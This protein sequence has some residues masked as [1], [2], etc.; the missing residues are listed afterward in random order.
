MDL[1]QLRVLREES[2]KQRRIR[3]QYGP[4]QDLIEKQRDIDNAISPLVKAT[5]EQALKGQSGL[6]D[7]RGMVEALRRDGAESAIFQL[8]RLERPPFDFGT[9]IHA[10]IFDGAFRTMMRTSIENLESIAR[11]PIFDAIKSANLSALNTFKNVLP[12]ILATS[13]ISSINKSW[14]IGIFDARPEIAEL[15]LSTQFSRISEISFLAQASLAGVK[16]DAI[17]S[18]FKSAH[19]AHS[20]AAH[21]TKLSHSYE[22]LFRSFDESQRR[23]FGLPPTLSRLPAVELFNGADLVRSTSVDDPEEKYQEE[24]SIVRVE[25]QAETTDALNRL[26][27]ELNPDFILMREGALKA[28]NSDNPDRVRHFIISLRELFTHVLHCLSPDDEFGK[29]DDEKKYYDNGRPTRKG[30]LLY[31]CRN[32]NQEPFDDFV[33][34]DIASALSIL[35]FFQQG[36]HQIS[37]PYTPVQIAALIV[38]MEAT[39]RFM[40][41]I[42]KA[43]GH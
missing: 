13:Q 28:L 2:E 41:E 3:E 31:I 5:R 10:H 43:G 38:R 27:Y 15:I 33:Q 34:K 30:R 25:I 6:N 16:A 29:W 42:W 32:L 12:D 14:A 20:M 26:L 7:V 22:S 4:F 18:I 35:N 8:M 23:L 1:E 39:L 19:A 24:A 11:S 21:F 37:C 9:G 40:L 17:G 36:T